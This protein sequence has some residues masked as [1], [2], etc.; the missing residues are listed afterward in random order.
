LREAHENGGKATEEM[1]QRASVSSS[2]NGDAVSATRQS[3]KVVKERM[4]SMEAQASNI[5]LNGKLA[6]EQAVIEHW[7]GE[8]KDGE[9]MNAQLQQIVSTM[10]AYQEGMA[11][12]Y[13]SAAMKTSTS[14]GYKTLMGGKN[15]ET[16]SLLRKISNDLGKNNQV[17]DAVEHDRIFQPPADEPK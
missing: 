14:D 13:S 15:G 4:G 16:N 9:A 11:Q 1:G 6:S 5:T 8:G 2:V 12:S 7:N 10:K 17:H 3:G